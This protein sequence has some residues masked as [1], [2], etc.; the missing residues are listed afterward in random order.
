VLGDVG[1]ALD[2]AALNSAFRVLAGGGDFIALAQN[3]VFRDS[4]GELSL[5]AGAFIAALEYASGVKALVLGKSAAAF[6]H[7]ALASIGC[8]PAEAVMV[9]D[10]A[11][12]DVAAAISAGLSGLLV[13]TGKYMS[14]AEAANFPRPTAVVDDIGAAVNWI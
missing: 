14:G 10:D 6:F 12:F 13:R 5:D 4:D 1:E 7:A 3:R 9:G 11:E 8:R 2:Y